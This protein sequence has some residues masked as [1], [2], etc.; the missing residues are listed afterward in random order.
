MQG[1]ETMTK[2]LVERG[3]VSVGAGEKFIPVTYGFRVGATGGQGD[4]FGH[5]RVW[6]DIP[7]GLIED[8]GV[9]EFVKLFVGE[10][11][12]LAEEGV[13]DRQRIDDYPQV[14]GCLFG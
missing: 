7:D 12:C 1:A 3:D 4:E 5:V 2:G 8:L 13:V 9:E 11:V 14:V 6:G 10:S